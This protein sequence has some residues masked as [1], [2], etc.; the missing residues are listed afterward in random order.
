MPAPTKP[1]SDGAPAQRKKVAIA[2]QGGGA[3]GAFTWGVLDRLLE[4]GRIEIVGISGVS[5]GS[6]NAVALAH[7]LDKGGNIGARDT[8][9]ALWHALSFEDVW[10]QFPGGKM[11]AEF[12][13]A[14]K[15]MDPTGTFENYTLETHVQLLNRMGFRVDAATMDEFLRKRMTEKVT[16]V[17]DFAKLRAK[18]DGVPVHVGATD[19]KTH[20]HTLFG[21]DE[22]D[23]QRVLASC[24]LPG[25]YKPVVI[26]GVEYWDGALSANP[27][28]RPLKDADASDIIVIQTTPVLSA[29]DKDLANDSAEHRTRMINHFMTAIT[30]HEIEGI[31]HE[32]ER[33]RKNPAAA[34]ALGLKEIHAHVINDN[35][36]IPAN[37]RLGYMNFDKDNL[38]KLRELG[39]QAASDWLARHF[40]DIGVKSTADLANMT[41]KPASK[42][43]N[44]PAK[45]N[46]PR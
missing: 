24:A 28:L 9:K 31:A 29:A 34:A 21:R 16:S 30:R 37:D 46:K 8:L 26:D 5:A 20:A 12:G 42:P 25:Y 32:N 1:S 35:G 19:I 7:G 39:R 27:S 6:M 2:L 44:P 41:K 36:K 13:R 23:M 45:N 15:R 14:I 4:D 17:I 40:D 10:G 38:K 3:Y 43:Q 33:V 18:D 22:L 11:A